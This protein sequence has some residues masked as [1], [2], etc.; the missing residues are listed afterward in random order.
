MELAEINAQIP[1]TVS[2][3]EK[4]NLYA[5]LN[6]KSQYR[7]EVLAEIEQEINVDVE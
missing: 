7:M 2:D 4:N 1:Q 3:E 6:D 5:L